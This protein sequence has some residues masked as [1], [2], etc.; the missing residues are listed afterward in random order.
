MSFLFGK[1]RNIYG[2]LISSHENEKALS[3]FYHKKIFL[4]E[5]DCKTPIS[6]IFS[7]KYLFY[8]KMDSRFFYFRVTIYNN[9]FLSIF[10]YLLNIR[11][12]MKQWN[13]ISQK[14]WSNQSY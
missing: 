1:N 11:T 7:Q 3:P 9:S 12:L 6:Y 13:L 8:D 14:F 5:K 2:K 4:L 10:R